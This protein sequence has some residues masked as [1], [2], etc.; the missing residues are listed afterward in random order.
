MIEG[1]KQI[2]ILLVDDDENY[3]KITHMYLKDNGLNIEAVNNPKVALKICKDQNIDIVLLDYFMPEL[4]GEEIVKEL[5][6]FNNTALVILQTG[7][8]EKK[9][10]IE[11]LTALDIQG[12]HDKTK[13]VDELLL[14]TLSAIKTM[15]LIKVNKI[16]E[17]K[18]NSLNYKKQLI[19]E[20]SVGL[21]N[22]AKD[23]LLAISAANSSIKMDTS[24]YEE[25]NALIEKSHKKISSA[26]AA[27]GFEA[28]EV[29]STYEIKATLNE[30]LTSKVKENL[31][32]INIDLENENTILKKNIDV[33]IFLIIQTILQLIKYEEKEINV[34]ISGTSPLMIN[35]DNK[36]KVDNDFTKKIIL[37]LTDRSGIKYKLQGEKIEIVLDN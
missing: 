34:R 21:L 7:F 17:V 10:P 20:L 11:T 37:L 13:G 2:K 28:S 35:F 6:K 5:R 3:T 30:L 32:K 27:L 36:I 31:L 15:K 25:E 26:F 4:T 24:D 16:Q 9:P 29:M 33:A 23:Q 18:I 19:G 22:E 8:S 1:L 12:Y 14:L